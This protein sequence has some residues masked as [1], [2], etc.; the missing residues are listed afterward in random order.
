MTIE[1][2]VFYKKRLKIDQL[3]A[4]GFHLIDGAYHFETTF[5]NGAFRAMI[6]V[7]KKGEIS[8]KVIDVLNDEEY[9]QLRIDSL[10]G[11]YVS[12][13]R[14][15]YRQL[16][17]DIAE[18]CAEDIL[19]K[20][21][22]ANRIT[23]MIKEQFQVLPDFPWGQKQYQSYGTFRHVE[24]RKWFA[25]IMDVKRD[26]LLKDG[27]ESIVDIINLKVDPA[28]STRLLKTKGIFPAYH[29]N[30]KTWISVMLDE[31]LSDQEIMELIADSFTLT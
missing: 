23:E 20:S 15:E 30:H 29:M 10:T 21:A 3:L 19:F 2:Q 24:S 17:A 25:L 8:G 7:S 26:V 18:K 14:D 1:E 13:V 4:Y 22:Q 16:L 27:D 31:N 6:T 12:Q 5:M 28:K 9:A 11:A